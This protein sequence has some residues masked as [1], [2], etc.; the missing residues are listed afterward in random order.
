MGEPVT[1]RRELYVGKL[2]TVVFGHRSLIWWGTL[3]MMAIEGTM[4][5]IVIASYFYLRTR[6]TDWPPGVMPP[7]LIYGVINTAIFIAS[8]VP[9]QWTKK[10]AEKGDRRSVQIGLVVMTAVGMANIVLRWF[11][12]KALNCQWD[13]NAYASVVWTLLGLHTVHLLTD[14]V[15]TVVLTTLFFTGPLDGKRYMDASENSDYWY[16]VIL[17]WLPIW[18]VIYLVPRLL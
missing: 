4:F 10:V 15:D 9:N 5:A 16:F 8:A 7:A 13:A 2:P 1:A 14:W 17:T 6:I 18:F 12:F 11:E 3:G